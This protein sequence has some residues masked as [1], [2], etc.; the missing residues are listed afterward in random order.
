MTRSKY[1][2]ALVAGPGLGLGLGGAEPLEQGP[3]GARPGGVAAHPLVEVVDAVGAHRGIRDGR[4]EDPGLGDERVVDHP[5]AHR[6]A[7]ERDAV[8]VDRAVGLEGERGVDRVDRV[9]VAQLAVVGR[10][11]RGLSMVAVV[12]VQG[13]VA[14][15]GEVVALAQHRLAVAV[16]R[17]VDVAVGEDDRREGAGAP[18]DVDPS[19]DRQAVAA[20]GR[21]VL[22]VGARAAPLGTQG[23]AAAVVAVVDE[24]LDRCGVGSRGGRRR[25]GRCGARAGGGT[26]CGWRAGGGGPVGRSG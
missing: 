20:V 16:G 7:D 22:P 8:G 10:V 3:R 2:R 15:S 5:A 9:P 6:P 12:D 1:V 26:R 4:L 17:A 25:G 13:H 24:R 21:V 19:R 11:L 23:Q 18:G 14:L